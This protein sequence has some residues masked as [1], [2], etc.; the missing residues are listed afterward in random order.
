MQGD[1]VPALQQ[2]GVEVAD[3]DMWT[4]TRRDPG[5]LIAEAITRALQ[6]H[7][8]LVARTARKAGAKGVKVAGALD[9]DASKIGQA[10][11]LALVDALRSL[12]QVA[13]RPVA[14]VIDEAQH[15]P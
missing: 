11:G 14:L 7:L 13:G 12:Q 3:V 8:G 6:P 15:A 1:L 10:D 9:I 2:A 5:V 4:D